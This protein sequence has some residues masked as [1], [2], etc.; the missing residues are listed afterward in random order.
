MTSMNL[1]LFRSGRLG[2]DSMKYEMIPAVEATDM[3]P[4][5]LE[6]CAEND[7]PTHYDS[8][9]AQVW[10]DEGEE[11]NPFAK[12]LVEIGVEKNWPQADGWLVGV[13]AT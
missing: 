13:F 5:V 1:N 9:I 2:E 7:I 6:W 10:T 4:D 8:T 3:P 11:M 12:W